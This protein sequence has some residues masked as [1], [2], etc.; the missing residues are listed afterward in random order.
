[1]QKVLRYHICYYLNLWMV[2]NKYKTSMLPPAMT[3][4]SQPCEITLS[5]SR[6]RHWRYTPGTSGGLNSPTLNIYVFLMNSKP[7]IYPRPPQKT[8]KTKSLQRTLFSYSI[9]QWLVRDKICLSS[10][11]ATVL[12]RHLAGRWEYHLQ[13]HYEKVCCSYIMERH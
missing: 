2:I 3:N 7:Y 6:G 12:V 1:M 5:T 10:V 13:E 11:S 4:V 9:T 8:K